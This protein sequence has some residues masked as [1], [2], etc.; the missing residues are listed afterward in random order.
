MDLEER[1]ES[2][3]LRFE[4][5]LCWPICFSGR[6]GSLVPRECLLGG[7]DK[8]MSQEEG[9]RRRCVSSNGSGDREGKAEAR[10]ETR[11]LDFE[12]RRKR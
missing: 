5:L 11:V 2:E 1:R 6:V 4:D 8:E 12:G 7:W 9:L 10:G 3:D